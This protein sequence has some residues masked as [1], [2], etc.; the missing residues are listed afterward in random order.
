M[1]ETSKLKWEANLLPNQVWEVI[2]RTEFAYRTIVR[3][4]TR[5]QAHAIADE[6]NKENA[7]G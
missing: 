6:H 5:D 2:E 7:N 1:A 3:G 4:I